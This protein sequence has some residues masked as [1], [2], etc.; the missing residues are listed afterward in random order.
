MVSGNWSDWGGV[1]AVM[2]AGGQSSRFGSD[3]ALAVLDGMTLLERVA[4]SFAGC[5]KRLLIA[6]AGKYD[7]PGWRVVP[8]TRPGEGPLAGLE[9]ALEQAEAGWVAFAG[10][11]MP[12]LTPGYWAALLTARPPDRPAVLSVQ[13]LDRLGRPQPLAAL[14]HT[15]LR[16][17][18]SELLDQGERRLSMAAPPEHTALVSG[19]PERFFVNVNRREDLKALEQ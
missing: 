18:I 12:F 11:D 19:L 4:G 7:L 5:S 3:K 15:D 17:R 9:T 8:D 14:Y 1:T 10:I 16:P 6:P 2:T 13:A